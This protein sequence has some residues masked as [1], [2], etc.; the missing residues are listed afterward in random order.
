MITVVKDARNVSEHPSDS[1]TRITV[2]EMLQKLAVAIN[3]LRTQYGYNYSIKINECHCISEDLALLFPSFY[4][5][6][7]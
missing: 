7:R 2:I 6:I 5:D 4:V 1:T 3:I